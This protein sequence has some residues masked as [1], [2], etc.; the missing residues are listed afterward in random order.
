MKSN[1]TVCLSTAQWFFRQPT[2]YHSLWTRVFAIGRHVYSIVMLWHKMWQ[3]Q[4]RNHR[5]IQICVRV[6]LRVSRIFSVCQRNAEQ[7]SQP[8]EWNNWIWFRCLPI[9]IRV[10]AISSIHFASLLHHTSMISSFYYYSHF[11]LIYFPL[12]MNTNLLPA[13]YFAASLPYRMNTYLPWIDIDIVCMLS[14]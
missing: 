11:Y 10:D 12:Q 2:T 13:P 8:N 3:H 6:H 4:P 5:W 1:K 7:I 9:H 14:Y